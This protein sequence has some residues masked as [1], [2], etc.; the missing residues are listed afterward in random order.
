[1]SAITQDAADAAWNTR[2]EGGAMNCGHLRVYHAKGLPEGEYYERPGPCLLCDTE[3]LEELLSNWY[4]TEAQLR[5][6]I[7]E[8]GGG[9]DLYRRALELVVTRRPKEEKT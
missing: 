1:V 4:R 8:L 9:D 7:S 6:A 5:Q 3:E 2:A